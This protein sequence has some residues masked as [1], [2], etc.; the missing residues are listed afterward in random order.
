M[1]SDHPHLKDVMTPFPH[2]IDIEAPLLE[3]RKM[4]LDHHVHHLPVVHAH[5]LDGIISDRDIKLVLGPEFDYPDPYRLTVKDVYQPDCYQVDIRTMLW[6]VVQ[7]M[8]ER[9]IGAAVVM[10]NGNLA[11]IFT[12]T[13]ACRVLAELLHPPTPPDEV[14]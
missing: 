5:K 1:K 4:M 14:A 7:T 9:H 8:A 2:A 11:G 6:E 3:A 12:V 13:D 10:R